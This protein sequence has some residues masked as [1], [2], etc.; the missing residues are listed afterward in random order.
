MNGEGGKG[1]GG[2]SDLLIAVG[3]GPMT[4]SQENPPKDVGIEPPK[5]KPAEL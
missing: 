3:P 1:G 5:E 4:P 2:M